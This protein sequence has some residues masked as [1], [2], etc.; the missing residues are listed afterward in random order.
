MF[1]QEINCP[2]DLIFG[3]PPGTVD[4]ECPVEYTE[5]LQAAMRSAFLTALENL[6]IAARR[7]KT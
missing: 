2:V 3:P 5:W 1:G 6:E 7:Q 4:I